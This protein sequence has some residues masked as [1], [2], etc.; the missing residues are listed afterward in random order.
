MSDEPFQNECKN[1]GYGARFTCPGCYHDLDY[2]EWC[3]ETGECPNCGL[4]VR[5]YVDS[6]P[7]SVCELH[8]DD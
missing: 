6:E 3:G 7:V 8:E 2:D 1:N 5:C 4:T